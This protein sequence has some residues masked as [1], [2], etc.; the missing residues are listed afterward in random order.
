MLDSD[1]NSYPENYWHCF[2]KLIGSSNYSIVND[3][4]FIELHR[5]IVEPWLKSRQFTISGKIVRSSNQ[6][7]EIKI[8]HTLEKLKLFVDQYGANHLIRDVQRF[9]ISKGEDYTY[10][11]LFSGKGEPTLKL[12]VDLV[13]Q[14]CKRLFWV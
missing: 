4:S 11:L 5:Q 13:E 14:L 3:L 12:D 2:V 7:E 8:T 1:I 9:P 6:V 10:D